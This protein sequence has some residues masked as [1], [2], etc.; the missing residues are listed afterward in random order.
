MARLHPDLHT[1]RPTR[2][3]DYTE[4]AVLQQLRDGLPDG[5]DVFHSVN[6]STVDSGTQHF[7]EIDAVVV[8][9]QGHLVL[10]EIKAG[11]LQENAW[12][13]RIGQRPQGR[14]LPGCQLI[15]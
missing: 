3:G 1:W 10:L 14:M 15:V 8:E 7:G 4:R 13:C 5:F 6:W 12:F 9:P 2:A 11:H